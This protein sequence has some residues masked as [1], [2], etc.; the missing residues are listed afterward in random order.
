MSTA[1]LPTPGSD[2]GQWGDILND[3]LGISHN[4][5][6]TLKATATS[7][8]GAAM[9]T[10][11]L[12]D[13]QNA[14]TS[15]TNLGLGDAATHDVGATAGTVAAGDD[16]RLV[17]AEQTTNKGAASGY[18][19]LDA[20]SK[21]PIANLPTGSSGSTVAIGNDPRLSDSR[22][23]SGTA[24]GD[25]G[26]SYPNPTVAKVN[27]VGISGTPAVGYVPTATG[28]T[29]AAWAAPVPGIF[30]GSEVLSAKGNVSGAITLDLTTASAFSMTLTG[31]TTVTF[32]GAQANRV[33]Y[34]TLRITQDA[35][36]GRTLTVTGARYSYGAAPVLSSTAGKTDKLACE[37]WNG[38]T[39]W[40][41]ALA[42]QQI[43]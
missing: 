7:D 11:N 16:P 17:N 8:A 32:T 10:N 25:L 27:G 36:G 20:G 29:G 9:T 1:R 23:P 19:P 28:A 37:S 5:D 15:R 4:P 2:D 41:V 22:V 13:L 3:F 38:G 43:Q 35:T 21:V 34:A 40:D 33:T 18:A 6:G 30:T 39:N 26:G 24:G 42:G 12:S 14:A 31:N